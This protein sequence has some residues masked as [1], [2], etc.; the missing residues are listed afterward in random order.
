VPSASTETLDRGRK[1]YAR[2]SVVHAWLVDPLPHTLEVMWLEAGRWTLLGKYEGDVG[3]RAAPF[4]AIEL[5]LSA[6]WI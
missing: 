2:E 6:L 4:D 5:E 1:I 3:V